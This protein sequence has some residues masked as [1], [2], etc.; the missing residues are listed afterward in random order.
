MRMSGAIRSRVARCAGFSTAHRGGAY[1]PIRAATRWWAR[2]ANAPSRKTVNLRIAAERQQVRSRIECRHEVR[3]YRRPDRNRQRFASVRAGQ[4]GEDVCASE[5]GGATQVG[6]FG[7]RRRVRQQRQR[8]LCQDRR[9]SPRAGHGAVAGS[10]NDP[11]SLMSAAT[12]SPAPFRTRGFS[13]QSKG[14]FMPS[15]ALNYDPDRR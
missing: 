8:N 1:L 11:R 3:R 2:C 9:L 14:R 10:H 5:D 4:A 15:T 6:L 12:E 7:I 13:M